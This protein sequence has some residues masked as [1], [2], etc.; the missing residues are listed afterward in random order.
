[1]NKIIYIRVI[2]V[3]LFLFNTKAF[4]QFSE[5]DL[6][7]VT[8]LSVGLEKNNTG[9]IDYGFSSGFH[10]NV[11]HTLTP[12]ELVEQNWGIGLSYNH[13]FN[14]FQF[15]FSPSITSNWNTSFINIGGAL[16]LSNLWKYN[17]IKLGI[18]YIPYY[19]TDLK[20]QNGWALAAQTKI[21][22]DISIFC[23]YGK[24][25]DYR[26]IYKRI[27]A[28]FEVK[29]L[30]L[31]VKPLLQIP[32]YYSGMKLTQSQILVSAYYTFH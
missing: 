13:K 5:S 23:E 32:I 14:F 9:W 6:R 26:I 21:H 7:M 12:I 19:D 17:I 30:D 11:K 1:M 8:G 4:S 31:C 10:I 22:K 20:F 18:E 24:K 28:G 16:K 15:S 3:L 25:A 29:L 27:Y 2:V